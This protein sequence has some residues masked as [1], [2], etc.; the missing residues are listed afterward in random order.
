MTPSS[1]CQVALGCHLC[2]QRKGKS[3]THLFLYLYCSVIFSHRWICDT[4]CIRVCT[5]FWKVCNSFQLMWSLSEM[6]LKL[7]PVSKLV[8]W[9]WSCPLWCHSLAKDLHWWVDSCTEVGL[10]HILR[11][12]VFGTCFN[13][14]SFLC[15]LFYC[16]FEGGVVHH[17]FE[18]DQ[19]YR[20]WGTAI[21]LCVNWN[22]S[23]SHLVKTWQLGGT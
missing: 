20:F 9:Q 10:K 1:P 22:W 11:H 6:S 7:F 14:Q 13:N 15:T 8:V 3:I 18:V 2:F 19:L 12:W 4:L 5:F 17:L 21:R 23:Y 16:F